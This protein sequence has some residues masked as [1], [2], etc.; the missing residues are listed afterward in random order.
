MSRAIIEAWAKSYSD[1]LAGSGNVIK[2]LL[3]KL[4]NL[5]DLKLLK[6]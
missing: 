6:L 1:C 5:I 3:N 2:T 4:A